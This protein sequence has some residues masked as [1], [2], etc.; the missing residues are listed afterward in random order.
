MTTENAEEIEEANFR[1]LRDDRAGL[2][3]RT[4]LKTAAASAVLVAPSIVLAQSPATALRRPPRLNATGRR[5]QAMSTGGLSNVR[6]GRMH[7]VMAGFVERGEVPGIVTLV[8]RR[9]A[10]AGVPGRFGWDGGYGTSW[11][12]D[13][14]EDMVGILL[15]QRLW[16]SPSP[17]NVCLDFWTSAYQ[18]IDD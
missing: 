14:R 10:L 4:F 1:A 8:S 5:E 16:T 17:P 2:D 12:S 3:R 13:P 6:L 18:A 9:D 11:A 7:S 15:T